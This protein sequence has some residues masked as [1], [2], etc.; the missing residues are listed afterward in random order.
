[1]KKRILMAIVALCAIFAMNSDAKKLSS[2]EKV[3]FLLESEGF[4]DYGNFCLEQCGAEGSESLYGDDN[5]YRCTYKCV[6]DERRRPY[7]EDYEKDM[8]DVFPDPA[9]LR[10]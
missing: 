3:D 4:R 8:T 7:D 2:Q 10:G 9:D 6:V 5:L 1:M